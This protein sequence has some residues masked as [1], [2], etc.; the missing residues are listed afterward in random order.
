MPSTHLP[1]FV[2]I[3][4][5]DGAGK[6]TALTYVT[7]RLSKEGYDVLP[8]SAMGGSPY[9][10]EIRKVFLCKEAKDASHT[11]QAMVSG[12]AI[13]DHRETVVKKA[14]AEGQIVICDRGALT[15]LAYQADSPHVKQIAAL[16]EASLSPNLVILLDI[17]AQVS[18]ERTRKRAAQGT[19]LDE[20]NR[21]DDQK[22]E[23]LEAKRK[24]MLEWY[25]HNKHR[26][27][28]I[29]ACGSL[30][31]VVSHIYD[32]ILDALEKETESRRI[33]HALSPTD[34]ENHRVLVMALT[35]SPQT[36][37]I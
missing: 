32:A 13:R 16:S 2:V 37:E 29:Q 27:A 21:Y 25:M 20:F 15:M 19:G 1:L 26:C 11:V 17:N 12:A 36:T 30:D 6:S 4:G 18:I 24:V 10:A 8:T 34:E 9:G 22:V 33:S 3:E 14:L 28:I 31:S 7:N 5:I 35:S 23:E